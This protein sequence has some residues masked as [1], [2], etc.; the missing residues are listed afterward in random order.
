MQ[1]CGAPHPTSPDL[2]CAQPADA[3]H[4][5]HMSRSGA[6]WPDPEVLAEIERPK[7]K[8]L[9]MAHAGR[10]AKPD[11]AGPVL[12]YARSDGSA[13]T[14]D[15]GSLASY[16]Q[17][18][19]NKATGRT[20]ARQQ[21]A[22]DVLAEVGRDGLTSQ[23][24]GARLGLYHGPASGVLSNLHSGDKIARLTETRDGFTI[25]VL[26]EHVDGRATAEPRTRA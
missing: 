23:Q 26:K 18:E 14:G 7:A 24:L 11:H 4:P 10:A 17:A 6:S 5:F 20:T 8:G 19:R 22:L 16:L 3:R 21:A 9:V 2:V 13:T 25:Y 12:P 15:G 1:R